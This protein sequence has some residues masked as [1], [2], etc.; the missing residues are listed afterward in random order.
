MD[1]YGDTQLVYPTAG[2]QGT[3]GTGAMGS[4]TLKQNADGTIG[5]DFFLNDAPVTSQEFQAALGFDTNALL[6]QANTPSAPAPTTLAAPTGGGTGGT[7]TPKDP[8]D[9]FSYKGVTYD[10]ANPTSMNNFFGV[11]NGDYST[12]LNDANSQL[13]YQAGQDMSA[14]GR[15]MGDQLN[16]FNKSLDLFNTGKDEYTK[17]LSQLYEGFGQGN[18]NR[19]N[20][21]SQ[22]SP[23]TYQSGQGSSSDYANTKY[24]QG[25]GE[26]NQARNDWKG[27]LDQGVSRLGTDYNNWM[28][29][30]Q[31]SL[32][33]QK[34]TNQDTYNSNRDT[35]NTSALALGNGISKQGFTPLADINQSQV[36]LSAYTPYTNFQGLQ[37]SP[38]A[39]MFSK[40]LAP[41]SQDPL[42]QTLGYSLPTKQSDPRNQYLYA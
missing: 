11:R 39:N 10:K 23:D 2:L 42:S 34:N 1:N 12:Q 6:T 36:D 7:A 5:A 8:N 22:L 9:Y 15:Q 17:Q 35:L 32:S 31:R 29:D 20:Y 18:V 27:S 14:Y 25:Y 16:S 26:T 13:D 38:G 33:N 19:Q 40:F 24:Q 28:S 3:T 37:S 41:K 4:Y 30:Y 21:F